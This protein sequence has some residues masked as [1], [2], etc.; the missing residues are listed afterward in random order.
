MYYLQI[1]I[2]IIIITIIII[3]ESLIGGSNNKM[4]GCEVRSQWRNIVISWFW[5]LAV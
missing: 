1:I 3:I 5:R 2:I 4:Y